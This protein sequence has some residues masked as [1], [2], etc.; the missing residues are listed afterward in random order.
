MHLG[1]LFNAST[2]KFDFVKFKANGIIILLKYVL[3][4]QHVNLHNMQREAHIRFR[5]KHAQFQNSA[6]SIKAMIYLLD[7]V[8][9]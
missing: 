9:K 3:L 5:N 2:V 8:F 4:L 7:A 6:P 1:A